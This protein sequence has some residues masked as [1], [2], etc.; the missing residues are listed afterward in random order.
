MRG[1]LMFTIERIHKKKTVILLTWSD[2]VSHSE[3]LEMNQQLQ[4]IQQLESHC[5]FSLIIDATHLVALAPD[6]KE[7]MLL[8]Q[9]LIG[10]FIDFL[11]IVSV[12]PTV[13]RQ[14]EDTIKYSSNIPHLH[15]IHLHDVLVHID[16]F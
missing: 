1:C 16:S 6:A 11:A 2:I 7:A 13:K 8:Q 15:F 3:I 9:Q 14:M 4:R 10:T 12:N 5:S